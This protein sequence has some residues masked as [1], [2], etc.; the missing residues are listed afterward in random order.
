MEY[1]Q[2]ISIR[3]YVVN[4][5]TMPLQPVASAPCGKILLDFG[6]R[7]CANHVLD[8]VLS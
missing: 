1:I 4:L 3:V 2:N 7:L 5:E 6:L 8:P